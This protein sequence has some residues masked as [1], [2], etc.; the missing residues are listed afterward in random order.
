[1]ELMRGEWAGGFPTHLCSS[2]YFML[3]TLLAL[4]C[5]HTG[6]WEVVNICR[7]MLL[8]TLSC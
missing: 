5:I 3:V 7:N 8:I 4:T 2:S 1:M 6:K